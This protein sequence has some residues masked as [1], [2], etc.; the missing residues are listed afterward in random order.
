MP[1]IAVGREK[2]VTFLK[3]NNIKK[4]DLAAAFGPLVE[5]LRMLVAQL[6]DQRLTSLFCE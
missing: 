3:S 5:P 6:E 1:D 4:S 2:V